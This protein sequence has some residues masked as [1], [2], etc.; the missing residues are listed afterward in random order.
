M[1]SLGSASVSL[2]GDGVLASA[3]FSKACCG[4]TP[5]PTRETR[6]LP[7]PSP[8]LREIFFIDLESDKTFYTA[9]LRGDRGI[10]DS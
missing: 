9:E 2:V 5:Q 10:P 4:E 8:G 7:K 1:R 3:D 6:A